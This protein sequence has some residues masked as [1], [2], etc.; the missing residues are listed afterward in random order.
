MAMRMMLWGAYMAIDTISSNMVVF[1]AKKSEKK[2][3][4]CGIFQVSG[5]CPWYKQD[6]VLNDVH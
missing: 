1:M 5:I 4:Q 6:L 3:E 2:T